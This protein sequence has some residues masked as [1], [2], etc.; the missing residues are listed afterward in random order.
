MRGRL[1]A[2]IAAVAAVVL[3]SSC[4]EPVTPP[5]API[6]RIEVSPQRG[7]IVLGATLQLTATLFDSAG[8]VI[9]GGSIAWA[10]V[11]SAVATVSAQGVVFG[12]GL[13]T[14]T[15]AGRVDHDTAAAIVDVVPPID[16]IIVIPSDV[17]IASPFGLQTILLDA[18][19][20][21]IRGRPVVWS[22]SDTSIATVSA[23]GVVS[24]RRPG[25]V[26]VSARSEN[27]VGRATFTIRTPHYRSVATGYQHSCAIGTDSAAY[28]WGGRGSSGYALGTGWRLSSTAPLGVRGGLRFRAITAAAYSSDGYSCGLTGDGRA[29]CWGDGAGF[30][31]GNGGTAST[32]EP[33]PVSGGLVFT[34]LSSDGGHTC[35]IGGGGAAYCW[36]R[37]PGGALGDGDSTDNPVPT[38]VAGGLSFGAIAAG[39]SHTCALTT[40]GAAYCWGDNSYGQLGDSGPAPTAPARQTAP[41]PVAGGLTFRAIAA[42]ARHSCGITLGGAAYCWGEDY[43]GQLGSSN[44]TSL[45]GSPQPLYAVACVTYPVPVDGGFAYAA[46]TA[47]GRKTCAL[48]T[49]GDAHCWGEGTLGQLGNGDTASVA[50]PVAVVG[51]LVFAEIAAG[52]VH[53]CGV[54]TAAVAYCWGAGLFGALGTGDLVA[55]NPVPVRVA[56]QP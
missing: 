18:A 27:V 26:T 49:G 5:S 28:C 47:G 23:A 6:H 22:S 50:A 35:G 36:G 51:G 48:R 55:S 19:A 24:G 8:R 15:I 39:G 33:V 54:T 1:V 20:D 34:A 38:P 16:S 44:P 3:D 52:P 25:T 13:G 32:L 46:I 9:H 17:I 40:A 21:T 4:A 37:G 10:S 31:L 53:V 45:C 29:Y 41:V 14:T 7:A 12:V 11:D 42:G 56:G 43:R 2:T 30:Q